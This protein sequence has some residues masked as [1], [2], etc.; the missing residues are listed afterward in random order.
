MAFVAISSRVQ[1]ADA[2][3]A[4]PMTINIIG[5][6]PVGSTTLVGKFSEYRYGL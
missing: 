1:P 5:K 2:S 4:I 3:K 6:R